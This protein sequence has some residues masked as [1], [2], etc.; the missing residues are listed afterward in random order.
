MYPPYAVGK[1]ADE[2][3]EFGEILLR[4]APPRPDSAR[5]RTALSSSPASSPKFDL[6][7]PGTTIE[8]WSNRYAKW[9]QVQ[10]KAVYEDGTIDLEQASLNRIVKRRADPTKTR[11]REVTPSAD[12]DGLDSFSGHDAEQP[13]V[14]LSM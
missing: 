1:P 14:E 10:V 9:L 8:Y 2:R 11:L 3:A 7:V 13:F 12:P 6:L 4:F 5:P